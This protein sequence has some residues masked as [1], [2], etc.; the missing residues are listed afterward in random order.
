MVEEKRLYDRLNL[1]EDSLLRC[2][3][4][5]FT[6]EGRVTV[7]GMGGAM[8]RSE[9]SYA[10]GTVLPLRFQHG[11]SVFEAECIVRDLLPGGF[12]VEFVKFRGAGE[13][14]LQKY[15]DSHSEAHA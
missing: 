2:E 3:G 13:E 7:I 14:A 15:L 5:G 9:K 10:I 11:E 1:G 12:G 6:F 8:I 4:I